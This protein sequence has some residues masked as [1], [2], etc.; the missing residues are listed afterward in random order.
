MAEIKQVTAMFSQPGVQRDG[1]LTDANFFTDAQWC[2]FQRGRPRKMGGYSLISA[3][4]AGPIRQQLVWSKGLMN[5]LYSFS[6]TTI[7]LT[8]MDANGSGSNIYNL[9]PAGFASSTDYLW[10]V[11]TLWDAAGSNSIV[12]AVATPSLTN[13]DDATASQVYYA[14][15]GATGSAFVPIT[16]LFASGGVVSIPP[17]LFYFGADGKVAWTDANQPQTLTG[18][19]ANTNARVTGAKVVKALPIRGGSGPAGLFWSLDSLVKGDWTGGAN[20][21]RF[22]TVSSQSSV[23]SQNG[24]IEYD[25]SYYWAG[26]DRFLQYSGGQISEIPNNQ[27]LNWFFDNLNFA[28]RQKVWA[29]KVPRFGEIMWFF[30]FG[31]ATECTHCVILNV[32][33]KTW[34]DNRLA[35][36]AGF[37]SQVF[38]YPVMASSEPNPNLRSLVIT[39]SAGTFSVGD[40][41]QGST[42]GVSATI[43]TVVDATHIIVYLTIANTDFIATEGLVNAT[44]GGTATLDE[45]IT[46][47][48]AYVHEKGVNAL[49]GETQNPIDSWFETC[50]FGYPTGSAQPNAPVGP[51]RW[52]RI[53]RIEPDFVQTGE[54]SVVVTGREWAQ[55]SD[56][57]SAPYV[58]DSTTEKIDMREQRRE[59]RL[60]FRSNAIDGHFE[61]GHVLLHIEPGDVRS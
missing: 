4:I 29:M 45:L 55:G 7:D 49:E 38:H 39:I 21:F 14:V 50:D 47:S 54:M 44:S 17:Y 20:V 22:T 56:T 6:P 41:I 43:T 2:R 33:E 25:G 46:I 15:A 61:T 5:A 11:D 30:P 58:F 12:V 16:G 3:Q 52:T 48:S 32:R 28:Q 10:S 31:T 57:E 36:S 40:V 1:T 37:Y 18:G 59:I 60:R 9:T 13:I 26:V 42:S 19:D 53:I 23:L 8:V 51:N 34:Y 24:V 35:R 27:N